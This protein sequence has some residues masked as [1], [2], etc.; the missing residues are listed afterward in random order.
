MEQVM[1]E[2]E[3]L[4]TRAL[5]VYNDQFQ[6]KIKVSDCAIASIPPDPHS[7][8]GYEITTPDQSQFF[9]IRF[10]V[11]LA[12]NDR[13]IPVRLEVKAP[14]VDRALGDEV[15]VIHAG[16]DNWYRTSGT[17]KFNPIVP[18]GLPFGVMVTED[19]IPMI[20]EDGAFLVIELYKE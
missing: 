14:F 18:E 13:S 5:N 15:Y 4:I 7:D 11:K 6:R 3:F 16:I 10:Y 19:G 9:R 17:Y 20:T 8:R 12:D 1:S 2:N